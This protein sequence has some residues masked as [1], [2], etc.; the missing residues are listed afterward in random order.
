M[1]TL[2]PTG[3]LEIPFNLT[4]MLTRTWSTQGDRELHLK[5]LL[6]IKRAETQ[7]FSFLYINISDFREPGIR[8][9][10]EKHD[11]HTFIEK[12]NCKVKMWFS[13]D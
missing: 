5:L 9:D 13:Y 3:N 10:V 2:T 6:Q 11:R 12:S 8:V 4:V 1:H 7:L